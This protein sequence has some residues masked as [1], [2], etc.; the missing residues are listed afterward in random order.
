MIP[1]ETAPVLKFPFL[2]SPTEKAVKDIVLQEAL[3]DG[4]IA[5]QERDWT[6]VV[7]TLGAGDAF[8]AAFLVA[9]LNGKSADLVLRAGAEFRRTTVRGG[10]VLWGTPVTR[11]WQPV[12]RDHP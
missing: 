11:T 12:T 6:A 5:N 7:D 3:E 2:T 1:Q 4:I 8:F 10:K 9:H